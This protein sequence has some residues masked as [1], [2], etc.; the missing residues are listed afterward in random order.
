VPAE[1]T[2]RPAW[3]EVDLSAVRHNAALLASIAAPARLCAVVKADAY[4]HS[5]VPVAEAALEAGADELAVA[6]V[7]EGAELREHGVSAPILVLSEPAPQ[8]M[9]EALALGLVPTLY[10]PDGV[11]AARKAA[12]A[13]GAGEH[14]PPFP[15]EVKVDTGMHRVGAAPGELAGLVA[16]V[17]AAPELRYAGLWTHFAVSERLE[18]PF[19]GEQIATFERARAELRAAGLPEP[20]RCH[21]ANSAGAI[22][23]PE[24]RYDL[25]RCGI[26][27]YGYAPS[28]EVGRRLG[29]EQERA[30][31]GPVGLR[32]VLSLKA[33][34]T[35]VREHEAGERLSYGRLRPLEQRS[36]VATV[37]LGYADGV[38]R[39]YFEAGG[40]VLVGGRRCP[41]AGTVT[42]D[43]LLVACEPGS[44][45]T[46]G[47][48]AVLIGEQGGEAITADEWAERLGTISYEVLT[49]IGPR[50]PRVMRE[51]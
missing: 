40:C 23:W 30:A 50:V 49:R 27:L 11:A 51:P 44:G 38:P 2:R 28:I 21:A 7:D 26:A 16:E 48:E 36:L 31:A 29:L 15:V 47:D 37:P 35:L 13:L 41:I 1:G 19:T 14:R 46:A 4:G 39:R 24:A 32:P 34:V 33:R 42:M 8:A 43:Q 5:A 20:G 12:A 9:E 22:A 45:V 18:D 10:T 3:A 6:L 25:V 17:A